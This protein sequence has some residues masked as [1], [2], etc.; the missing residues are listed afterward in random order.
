MDK[1]HRKPQRPPSAEA[2]IAP[3]IVRCPTCGGDSAYASA[4]AFRPFC[5]ERCKNND[6]GAWASENFRVPGDAPPDDVAF[7]DPKLQ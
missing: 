6:F 4:N 1:P 7:G 3:R 2:A 5:S